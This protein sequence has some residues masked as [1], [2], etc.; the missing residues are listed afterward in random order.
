MVVHILFPGLGGV[1]VQN[2]NAQE[3]NDSA[4]FGREHNV[5]YSVVS[6]VRE[7]CCTYYNERAVQKRPRIFFPPTKLRI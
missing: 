5:K 1:L 4:F 2:V 7:V 3:T 6:V